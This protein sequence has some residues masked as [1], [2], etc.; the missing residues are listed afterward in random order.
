MKG[1][2][3][4][5]HSERECNLLERMSVREGQSLLLV[6]A[7]RSKNQQTLTFFFS[8][9]VLRDLQAT[10]YAPKSVRFI[11]DVTHDR[12]VVRVVRCFDD[13]FTLLPQGVTLSHKSRN[14]ITVIQL[15]EPPH[16]VALVS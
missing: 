14:L 12:D 11:T 4:L 6:L 16:S 15:T 3:R 10:G 2:R 8:L 7:L 9:S 5:L 1:V 13:P